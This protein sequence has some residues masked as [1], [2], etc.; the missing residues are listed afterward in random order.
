MIRD[1]QLLEQ[2]DYVVMESTYGDRN[3]TEVWSY[4]DELAQIIDETLGRGGN[5]VFVATERMHTLMDFRYKRKYSAQAGEN[6]QDLGVGELHFV[7]YTDK[8]K[9]E[10]YPE[11]DQLN[12]IAKERLAPLGMVSDGEFMELSFPSTSYYVAEGGAM[13]FD[14][15]GGN[16]L[17]DLI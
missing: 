9:E 15:S 16:Q 13:R 2:A 5:V 8:T 6:G 4:T 11:L 10:I 14:L 17:I 12:A 1:P 7:F 3:H